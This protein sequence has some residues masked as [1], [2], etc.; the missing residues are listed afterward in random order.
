MKKILTS[1]VVAGAL[2]G[3]FAHDFWVTGKNADKFSADIGYGHGFPMPEKIEDKRV[4]LFDPLYIVDKTGAKT[5]LKQAGENYH[6]EGEKLKKGSYVLAGDYKPTFWSKD[7]DGKWHQDG[8]KENVKNVESCGF[9]ART[10]KSIIVEGD[11]V[12][13]F[14]YKPI[15]QIVEIVPLSDITKIKVDTPFKLQFFANGKP[16]KVAKVTGVIEG[17]PEGKYTFFGTTDLQ[18]VIEVIAIKEGNWLFQAKHETAY[19]DPK[20]CDKEELDASLVIKVNK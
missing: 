7:K 18:G 8:H 13:D 10:A 15:G 2:S 20:K 19:A 5:V 14:I 3:A 1:L 6:Y 11:Q 9:H 4:G 12:E 17:F 16:A